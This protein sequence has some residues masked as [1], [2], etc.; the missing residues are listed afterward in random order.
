MRLRLVATLALAATAATASAAFGAAPVNDAPL[1]AISILAPGPASGASTIAS[2]TTV[3]A[4]LDAAEPLASSDVPY[5]G[6]IW[7]R[8]DT[9]AGGRIVAD[10]CLTPGAP[11]VAI[12]TGPINAAN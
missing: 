7:F 2:G 12:V 8:V 11:V 9:P 10:T 3:D 5:T 6:S 4:T 1:G